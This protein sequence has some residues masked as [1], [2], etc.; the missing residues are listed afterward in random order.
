MSIAMKSLFSSDTLND[1]AAKSPGV[2]FQFHLT[3]DGKGSFPYASPNIREIYGVSPEDVLLDASI[4]LPLVNPFDYDDV[5]ESI[6][7]SAITLKDWACEYR[8][9]HPERGE[10][11]LLGHARPER[12]QN[13][14][15]LWHGFITDVSDKKK[16]EVELV[17]TNRLYAL[18]AQINQ[19]VLHSSDPEIVL[20]EASR[21]AIESGNYRFAWIGKLN[22]QSQLVEPVAWSGHEEGYLSQMQPISLVERNP[23]NL[24]PTARSI[25]T[26]KTVLNNRPKSNPEYNLWLNEAA[27]RG[28]SSSI[29]LPIFVDGRIFGSFNLYSHAENFFTPSEVN[30]LETIAHNISF[31]MTTLDR[32]SKNLEAQMKLRKSEEL[33]SAIANFSPDIISVLNPTGELIF[34][35]SAALRIHGY[36]T[37]DLIGV[38]TITLIHPE[39]QEDVAAVLGKLIQSP[40]EYASVQYRYRNKDGSYIW[41][42]ATGYNQL[43]NPDLNG[44]IV[45]SRD[46]GQRKKMEQDL[47]HALGVRDE[48]LSIASHELKTPLTSVKLILQMLSREVGPAQETTPLLKRVS[49]SLLT[50]TK[51]VDRIT[52]LVENLLDVTRIRA[53]KLSLKMEI[54]DLSETLEGTFERFEGLISESK[55]KVRIHIEPKVVGNW[56]RGRL[57]QVFVNLISNAIKYADGAEIEISLT[58]DKDCAI[59]KVK[60]QGPGVPKDSHQAIFERFERGSSCRNFGGLGLGLFIT[61]QIVEGH[62]GEIYLESE[63]TKGSCFIVKIPLTFRQ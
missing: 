32:K 9:N 58:K 12:V 62:H 52:D 35:S 38:N 1:I 13:G 11:W 27:K 5:L 51:Q 40:G 15:T 63:L 19:M 53:G 17:K 14:G 44:V 6:R 57:E 33:F 39:D 61:K 59:L 34:N 2:I 50:C 3:A 8:V 18:T 48:F 41:M 46:I 29:A 24:G 56:D 28:Y 16:V 26:E 36:T 7:Q 30:L 23:T 25:L 45:I 60:D 4:V 37:E 31:A 21:I 49:K 42:E 54:S 20:N 47:T 22:H 10:I 43:N 55:C